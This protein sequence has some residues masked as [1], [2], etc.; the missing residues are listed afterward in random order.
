MEELMLENIISISLILFFSYIW[1]TYAVMP[2]FKKE[3]NEKMRRVF[4]LESEK[5]NRFTAEEKKQEKENVKTLKKLIIDI[6][7]SE[8]NP[9]IDIEKLIENVDN[10]F[11]LQRFLELNYYSKTYNK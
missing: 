1:L 11:T 8:G 9:N 10:S 6:H 7:K 5:R 2:S 3:E 4:M